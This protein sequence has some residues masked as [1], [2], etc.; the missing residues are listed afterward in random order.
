MEHKKQWNRWVDP[1]TTPIP[2]EDRPRKQKLT[3]AEI[4]EL[5]V[6]WRNIVPFLKK[7]I[8]NGKLGHLCKIIGLSFRLRPDSAAREEVPLEEEDARRP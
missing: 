2:V 3:T 8:W 7:L 1:P 5:V 4:Q 6:K